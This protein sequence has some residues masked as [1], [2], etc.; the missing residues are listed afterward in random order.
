VAFI[1]WFTVQP[2]MPYIAKDL[3]LTKQEIWTSNIAG[4]GSTIAVRLIIGPLCDVYGAR[5]L[6]ASLLCL[7]SIPAACLGFV[8]TATG[9]TILRSFIGIIGATFVVCEYWCSRVFAKK[10]VGTAQGLAAGWGNLGESAPA[11]GVWVAANQCPCASETVCLTRSPFAA[12]SFLSKQKNHTGA[13]F[14]NLL[15]GSVLM[16]IFVALCGGDTTLAWRTV[17]V[18]PAAAAFVTGVVIYR[19]SDDAPKGNYP[20]LRR[21]GQFPNPGV[22]FWSS[23]KRGSLNVNSWIM[24]VQYAGCF[25]V[26]I[27]MNQAIALYFKA[28]FGQSTEACQA[29][30]SMFGWLNL[31]ARGLG[32][33]VSDWSNAK[34]GMRGRLWAQT[35]MLLAEGGMVF[36]FCSTTTLGGALGS[37]IVFS[38][39]VQAAEGKE[40]SRTEGVCSARIP[41]AHA[42][43]RVA[44]RRLPLSSSF[45]F[46]NRHQHGHRPV[47]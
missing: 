39:F 13:G 12:Y 36:V 40:G 16:P 25:G 18:V 47:R 21:N 41:L 17:S 38:L 20:E 30:A 43:I 42:P 26:E 15:M 46:R 27:A 2:L 5:I 23:W 45:L 6:F 32:G 29:I 7:V 44:P 31:F 22:T 3:E 33:F 19:I 28:E 10:V 34:W 14:T 4:V 8:K 35:L 37:L 24:F 1:V 11:R 9:L